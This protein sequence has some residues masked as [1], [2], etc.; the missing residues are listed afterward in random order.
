[1][2]NGGR[3]KKQ[4]LS[5]PPRVRKVLG[6]RE[7]G[8]QD[9][10]WRWGETR[11]GA[12]FGVGGSRGVTVRFGAPGSGLGTPLS[13]FPSPPPRGQQCGLCGCRAGRRDP[14][15][16]WWGAGEEVWGGAGLPADPQHPRDGT[17]GAEP[18]GG[19]ASPPAPLTFFPSL[20]SQPPPPSSTRP[21]R[22][23][24]PPLSPGPPRSRRA[25]T[26]PSP[27]P[28]YRNPT[29]LPQRNRWRRSPRSRC[30]QP[31]SPLTRA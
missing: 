27:P 28:S 19:F 15:L 6:E 25:R 16:G 26:P 7:R 8:G 9:G 12:G 24:C 4:G 13:S 18:A 30:S 3:W 21:S 1:M 2:V 20:S 14:S 10:G 11:T 22:P 29:Q 31:D 5:G 17:D 23:R